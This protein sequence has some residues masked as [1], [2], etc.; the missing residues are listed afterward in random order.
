MVKVEV[1]IASLQELKG[2]VHKKW[3]GSKDY[4]LLLDELL[5]KAKQIQN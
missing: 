2:M 5:T 1:V 4:S 3:T